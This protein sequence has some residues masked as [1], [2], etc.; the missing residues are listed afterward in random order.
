MGRTTFRGDDGGVTMLGGRRW[1]GVCDSVGVAP[2]KV[3]SA[4]GSRIGKKSRF[5][6][7]DGRA[8]RSFSRRGCASAWRLRFAWLLVSALWVV[9]HLPMS[10]DDASSPCSMGMRVELA[11][12]PSALKKDSIRQKYRPFLF[13]SRRVK[14]SVLL[15]RKNCSV[16]CVESTKP[17]CRQWTNQ[18]KRA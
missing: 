7:M 11:R 1:L 15:T 10:N 13:T 17:S 6:G 8:C 3:R 9:S 5:S 2:V 16:P 4:N 12:L 14:K 18:S